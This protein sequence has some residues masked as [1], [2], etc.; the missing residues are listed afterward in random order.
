VTNQE[1]LQTLL[2]F[3]GSEKGQGIL[4]AESEI[5]SRFQE[6]LRDVAPRLNEEASK[7]SSSLGS[8]PP[9]MPR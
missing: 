2:D 8:W 5:A 4:N 7:R 6:R 1:K 3:Y 9:L